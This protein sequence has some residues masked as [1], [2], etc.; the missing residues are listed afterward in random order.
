MAV[1]GAK[2]VY[3]SDKVKSEAELFEDIIIESISIYG[4]NI[5]YIPRTIVDR[6]WVLNEDKESKFEQA[7]EL[8]MYIE[9][10]EGFGGEGDL[11]Q[12]FGL[13]IRDEITFISAKRTWNR[14]VGEQVDLI[15]PNEGD[16]IYIPLGNS[17]FGISHVEHQEPFF[18]LS[19]LPVYKLQ[20]RLFEYSGEDIDTGIGAVDQFESISTYKYI[21]EIATSGFTIGQTISQTLDDGVI[22]SAEILSFVDGIDTKMYIGDIETSDSQYHEF[23]IS[24]NQNSDAIVGEYPTSIMSVSGLDAFANDPYAKNTEIQ[25]E[26]NDIID[27]SESNP[28]GE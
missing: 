2:S 22:I 21:L 8:P 9:N 14:Y 28:F 13:E 17:L 26:A 7:L 27:W 5:Y 23:R 6:D 18:Q 1:S 3:F 16:L 24:P 11:F 12:K 4:Q 10:V 25:N 15:R 19:N 20:C